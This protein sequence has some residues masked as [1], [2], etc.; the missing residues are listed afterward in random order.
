MLYYELAKKII[1]GEQVPFKT[2]LA[3]INTSDADTFLLLAAANE[4]KNHFKGNKVKLCAIVNAK[5][6][7]CSENCSFCAQSSHHK[8]GAQAYPL[9]AP[10]EM[11]KA[12]KSSEKDM[13]ATCFSI[14]T[15]GKSVFSENEMLAIGSAVGTISS[16]TDLNRC[17]SLGTLSGQ[18]I[19][20]LKSR[21]L[22]R[23]HHNLESAESF[24]DNIC[25]THTYKER[26]DT[27]KSAKSEGLEVCSGGIF[28]LG[29][30]LEQRVELAITL[31]ELG[32]ESVPINI[33]NPIAGTPAAAH[34]IP[35]KPLEALRLVATYRFILPKADI[36]IFGGREKTLRELQPLMFIAGAN[37]TLVGNYLTTKGQDASRDLQM[38]S[39]LGLEIDRR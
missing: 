27:I 18:Q 2:A 39:D 11:V 37:V 35:V 36:G 13:K 25:T 3:L 15:S 5:S 31:S 23:L 19:R 22:K 20:E 1:N 32:V 38:I 33:L 12:A 8:T 9:M 4:I 24:F 14:V 17:V 30:S 34:F 28:G 21:G 6:G 10:D 7:K 29:E 26:L 16:E